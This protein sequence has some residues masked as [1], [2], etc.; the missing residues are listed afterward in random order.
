MTIDNDDANFQWAAQRFLAAKNSENARSFSE[1][2]SDLKSDK[3]QIWHNDEYTA[4]KIEMD[5]DVMRDCSGEVLLLHRRPTSM[6][7]II[8][9]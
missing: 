5:L 4:C 1:C 8:G 7:Q 9:R 2:E 3:I 6:R